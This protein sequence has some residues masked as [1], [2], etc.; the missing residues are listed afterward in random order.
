MYQKQKNNNW[1]KSLCHYIVGCNKD[2]LTIT[3]VPDIW[4]LILCANNEKKKQEGSCHTFK[5]HT[6]NSRC[7]ASFKK[8]LICSKALTLDLTH[9]TNSIAV[10]T[11]KKNSEVK[12]IL[13][14]Q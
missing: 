1:Q 9:Y 6:F 11:R 7:T 12:D 14:L 3:A 13:K 5:Q 2:A 10:Y 8:F 4:I